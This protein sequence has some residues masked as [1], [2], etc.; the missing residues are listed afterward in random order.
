M[1]NGNLIIKNGIVFD[2]VAGIKGEKKDIFIV[3]G[4]I[5]EREPKN[6]K[7]IDAGNRLV[8]PGA[9]DIHSHYAGGK[10]TAGRILRPEDNLRFTLN[11]RNSL[12]SGTGFSIP[13]SF[14][15]GYLYAKLG[16]TTAFTPAMPPLFARHTHEELA[17]VPILDKGAYPT[18]DGNWFVMK[19]V[20]E[21]DINMLAACIA[22]FLTATKGFVLKLVNPGGTENWAWGRNIISPKDRVVHFDVSSEEIIKS[23]AI[24]N[25]KLDLPC[26]VHVHP[27]NLGKPGNYE[28]TLQT[29]ELMQG[30]ENKE[31][32]SFYLAHAQFHSYG[33]DSWKNFES[34]ADEIA[35]H[36]N[37]KDNIVIDTGNVTLDET[38]TMTSDGPMEYFLSSLTHLKWVNKDVELET[39]PGVTPYIYSRKLGVCAIQWAIG[40]ELALLIKDPF[41]V[42]L[43]TD[44]PN[45]GPFIRYPRI[46]SW[47]MSRE[48][49]EKEMQTMNKAVEKRAIIASIDR[50]LDFYEIA[51]I[52][53]ATQAR[54]LR[55]RDKGTLRE[56]AIG[57]VAIYDINPLDV[58]PGKEYE[59][60]EKAFSR[61]LYTIKEGNIV[62][63]DGE[64]I[65]NARGSTHWCNVMLSEKIRSELV[66]DL[67]YYFRRFYSVNLENYPV[68]MDYI[69][70]SAPVNIRAELD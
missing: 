45:G 68:E 63:K 67:D 37:A 61:A 2:P 15:A 19:Y 18:Y 10:E 49:R 30:V 31:R 66:K 38:T 1:E 62:V 59:R 42:M 56:G 34:K 46:I 40:L 39:A 5:S 48:Y 64:V 6:A 21:K 69:E 23:C 41:K 27:N 58:D 43:G 4:R 14:T 52:T 22:W 57:D 13:S 16:Y 32:Q 36:V 26:S 44:H 28:I 47:L 17:D 53:R 54:A 29:L 35:S 12:R 51:C 33:G 8:L 70:K 20:K 24:A 3:N 55:L 9:I 11:K 7:V 25:E 60:I 65:S 50:E